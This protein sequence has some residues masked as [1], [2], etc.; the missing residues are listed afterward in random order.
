MNELSCY[1]ANLVAY[2]G[3]DALDRLAAAIRLDVRTDLADGLA[4]RHHDRI[5]GG[6]DG[7]L[8]YRSSPDWER[9]RIGLAAELAAHGRVLAVANTAHLP[10]APVRAPAS[11]WVLI[12][13]HDGDWWRVTDHFE[14]LLP[15]GEQAFFTGRLT[16]ATLRAALTPVAEPTSALL[17]RDTFALGR[18][19]PVPPAH[20]YRWLAPHTAEP[21][22]DDGDW[23]TE[24]PKALA[25]LGERFAA[26]PAL[27][28]THLDDLWAAARHQ[29]LSTS[30]AAVAAA[31]ADLPRTLRFAADSARRGRPRPSLVNAVFDDLSDKTAKETLR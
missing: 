26:D 21:P 22:P 13:A 9:T 14:A 6:V 24:L 16:D 25:L 3:G 2:L 1:T 10:W 20:H 5:D 7:G 11:H 29:R 30:D 12:D 19:V 23:C 31:W 4:F 17:R 8:G 27:L 28:A 15:E 18:A